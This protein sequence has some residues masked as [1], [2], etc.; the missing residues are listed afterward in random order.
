MQAAL[1]SHFTHLGV[2]MEALH[3]VDYKGVFSEP[4]IHDHPQPFQKG[5]GLNN[6]LEV[7]I[8]KTLLKKAQVI[9]N[10][11]TNLSVSFLQLLLEHFF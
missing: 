4:V 5:R 9:V 11:S 10:V 7:G 1:A 6:G 8:I 2:K 3:R